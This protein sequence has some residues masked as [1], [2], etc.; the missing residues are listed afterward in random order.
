MFSFE[1]NEVNVVK[2]SLPEGVR[3]LADDEDEAELE[4]EFESDDDEDE[5]VFDVA[6]VDAPVENGFDWVV[7]IGVVEG[8]LVVVVVEEGS[9][10]VVESD[11]VELVVV[12]VSG[13][14]V[15][16][17]GGWDVVVVVVVSGD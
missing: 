7:E 8:G 4:L 16:V 6:D 5:T 10:V 1:M 9:W 11:V 17:V 12:D 15:V 13:F 2:I 3:L 14:G